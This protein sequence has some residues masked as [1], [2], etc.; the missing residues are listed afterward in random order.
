MPSRGTA[1]LRGADRAH[2]AHSAL[3]ESFRVSRE[4]GARP[5]ARA[6]TCSVRLMAPTLSRLSQ[7]TYQGIA[8]FDI[9]HGTV[10]YQAWDGLIST[11]LSPRPRT[12][13]VWLMASTFSPTHIHESHPTVS[14]GRTP[15]L[16][17]CCLYLPAPEA[18]TGELGAEGGCWWTK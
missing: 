9:G 14:V 15:S 5:R 7:G 8:W 2:L 18:V 12:C 1:R 13:S 17:S 3:S 11:S 16:A 10:R 6:R 4:G